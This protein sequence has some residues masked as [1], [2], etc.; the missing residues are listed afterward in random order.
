MS[1]E[2]LAVVR[3]CSVSSLEVAW[4]HQHTD[5]CYEILSP[6]PIAPLLFP[7]SAPACYYCRVNK[8]FPW[9]SPKRPPLPSHVM[10]STTDSWKMRDKRSWIFNFFVIN[11]IFF[12]MITNIFLFNP[13]NTNLLCGQLDVK[14]FVRSTQL[15]HKAFGKQF[16]KWKDIHLNCLHYIRLQRAL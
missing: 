9:K 16:L 12:H 5:T 10:C 1:S 6:Q 15:D 2:R 11:K 3:E 7:F 8:G 4:P 13:K 14:H